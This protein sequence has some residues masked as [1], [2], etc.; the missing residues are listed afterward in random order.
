MIED[1]GLA[2]CWQLIS[3]M[4]EIVE[5]IRDR[6]EAFVEVR[7]PFIMLVDLRRDIPRFP[8]GIAR[9]Q[10]G[11]ECRF[12]QGDFSRNGQ[13]IQLVIRVDVQE[14]NG[15]EG[16]TKPCQVFSQLRATLREQ[17]L[18]SLTVSIGRNR[19]RWSKWGDFRCQDR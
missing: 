17:S 6:A 8:L 18:V 3:R 7:M 1:V 2:A 16:P 4:D 14:I 5:I 12:H 15:T 9:V 11:P 13:I 10:L 19:G